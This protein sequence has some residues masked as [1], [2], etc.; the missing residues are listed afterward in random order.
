M[1]LNTK[2]LI[3]FGAIIGA[4]II[5]INLLSFYSFREFSLYTAERHALSVAETVQEGL[6]ENMING[7]ITQRPQFLNRLRSVPGVQG[8]RVVRG[9]GVIDQFGQ[10]LA[11]ER[12]ID[13]A[14]AR[15]VAEGKPHFEIV[16]HDG[17]I[18]YRGIVPYVATDHGVP[19]C[20]TCHTGG[21]GA[22]LGAVSVDIPLT[23][24]RRQAI[25][26]MAAVNVSM[27]IAAL[28]SLLLLR[29]FMTPLVNT[30][31]ALHNVVNLAL[32]GNFSGRID[33]HTSD[34]V[35]A[36]AGDLNQLM[37]F[38][39]KELHS[40]ST[41]VN[42]LMGQQLSDAGNQLVATTEMVEN[43]VAVAKFKQAIEED[44]NKQEIYRRLTTV[45]LDNYDYRQMS[46]Y[47]VA[48]SKNRIATMVV[49]GEAGAACRWCDP[50]IL[51][52]ANACRARRTGHEV[53]AVDFPGICTMFRDNG[54]EG[55]ANTHICMPITQSGMVGCV[56]QVVVPLD[57]GRLAKLM[58]PFVAVYLREAAPVLEAKRLME[59]LRESSLRDAM[60]G[61]YNR[62]FLEEYVATLVA[63]AVR[64][65]ATFSV[66]MLDLDHFKQVNDTF[67]HEAG[68][69]VLKAL[70]EILGKSI[71]TSDLLIRYGGEEFLIILLDSGTDDALRVAENIRAR[72]AETKIALPTTQLQKTI[73]IGVAEFPVDADNFWQVV[74]FADV[75][76][77]EAKKQGRNRVVRFNAEM[78]TDPV[79]Y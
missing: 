16:E 23:E 9:P 10:G 45:L 46:I 42:E 43:L 70:A 38:L 18:F 61:L 5:V 19:N 4:L 33:Q 14:E 24:V 32:G 66:L 39:E 28:L 72:V 44:Q 31:N 58:L 54:T 76:L 77:Y 69:R 57:Q 26:T 35:G 36:I 49:D 22:V 2:M 56:V 21:E 7:T 37:G 47:E 12:S 20:M 55:T 6:T 64:K 53:N 3:F 27:L 59:H 79:N 40:V 52:D 65:K 13:A 17:E 68:D 48:S 34:E 74:K 8:V 75:A 62:R 11:Q 50:E 1:S 63:G 60:T 30:A 51:V 29:R 15:V 67:G 71:R 78:W 41:Q 25:M 73:S